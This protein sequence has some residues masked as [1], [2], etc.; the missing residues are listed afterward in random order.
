[1]RFSSLAGDIEAV[2]ATYFS[3]QISGRLLAYLVVN[4]FARTRGLTMLFLFNR[5]VLQ[6]WQA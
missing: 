5:A 4:N 3:E 1:M 2:S 6:P